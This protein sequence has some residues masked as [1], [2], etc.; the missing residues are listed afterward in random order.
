MSSIYTPISCIK[1]IERNAHL[2]DC[3]DRVYNPCVCTKIMVNGY[4]VSVS[5]DSSLCCDRDLN[6]TDIRVYQG[7]DDVTLDVLNQL[8]SKDLIDEDVSILYS[9]EHLICV[10]MVLGGYR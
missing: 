4:E 7:N 10:M 9:S 1:S 3:M 2:A 6:R 8:K 5:M